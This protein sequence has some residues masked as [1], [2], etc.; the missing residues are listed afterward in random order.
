M[1]HLAQARGRLLQGDMHGL[2]KGLDGLLTSFTESQ[3][4]TM[5]DDLVMAC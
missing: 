2:G 1:R 3:I 5:G 4:E